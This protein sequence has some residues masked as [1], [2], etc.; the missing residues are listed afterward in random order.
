MANHN[1]NNPTFN[2]ELRMYEVTDR[3]HANVFNANEDV[4]IKNDAYLKKEVDTIKQNNTASNSDLNTHKNNTNIHVTTAEKQ[5]WNNKASTN[6]ATTSQ[7]GLM[8]AADKQTINDL[9]T[10][11]GNS[12]TGQKVL[13][14]IK[15]VDGTGSG[16]DADLLDGKEA[17]AFSL[18][19]HSHNNA[20]TSQNGFMSA[21]DKQA[22]INNTDNTI[23]NS[24][25]INEI[26][27]KYVGH[28]FIPNGMFDSKIAVT[29]RAGAYISK[30]DTLNSDIND[31]V[32]DKWLLQ[33]SNNKNAIS[34]VKT[35]WHNDRASYSIGPKEIGYSHRNCLKIRY[36]TK[37]ENIASSK[38]RLRLINVFELPNA[39]TIGGASHKGDDVFD[40]LFDS[41]SANPINEDFT[42]TVVGSGWKHAYLL[43]YNTLGGTEDPL[44]S[45]TLN[46]PI[47]VVKTSEEGS[48]YYGGGFSS[49]PDNEPLPFGYSQV[50]SKTFNFKEVLK[51][52]K[53][54]NQVNTCAV[55]ILGPTYSELYSW[56]GLQN[57]EFSNSGYCMKLYEV[58][59][60]RGK[61]YTE[62]IYNHHVEKLRCQKYFCTNLY[63]Q[64]S[65]YNFDGNS[66]LDIYTRD[67]ISMM[68]ICK[69]SFTTLSNT[70]NT[71]DISPSLLTPSAKFPVTMV[72]APSVSISSDI[73]FDNHLDELY[74]L[75]KTNRSYYTLDR[76]ISECKKTINA[77]IYGIR[78]IEFVKDDNF[79]N[80]VK[81][82]ILN[83]INNENN[84][85]NI[86]DCINHYC[87]NGFG[88]FYR[89]DAECSKT[90]M[91]YDIFPYNWKHYAGIE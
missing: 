85:L 1:V 86:I 14:E 38:D 43:F 6:L 76:A 70:S 49:N 57:F 19:N 61:C 83:M 69:L 44:Y 27:S 81:S 56:H 46:A 33:S 58:K 22:M 18:T 59:L 11:I 90:S 15:K 2:P 28:N 80:N 67:V 71:C 74:S 66:A 24:K 73:N 7:N 78:N 52:A 79:N 50:V 26:C 25:E 42:F 3:G 89:A 39:N 21:A 55:I 45:V 12:I 4:L 47:K 54:I 35:S 34:S 91:A 72:R 9:S 62:T 75:H 84:V 32:I 13:T 60:E 23:K 5:T 53:G 41:T 8:S 87:I 17:S 48:I 37:D 40:V 68:N 65:N 20:T 31:Y 82:P 51:N 64:A 36:A 16:L 63:E 88:Y 77:N 10:T 30:I 29:Y